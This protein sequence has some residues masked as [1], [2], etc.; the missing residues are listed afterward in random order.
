VTLNYKLRPHASDSLSR[1]IAARWSIVSQRRQRDQDCNARQPRSL[2]TRIISDC[3]GAVEIT[4]DISLPIME[5]MDFAIGNPA[6]GQK[7]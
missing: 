1:R 5:Y 2:H 3:G 7:R 6:T 4:G